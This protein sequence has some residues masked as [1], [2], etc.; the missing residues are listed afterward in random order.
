MCQTLLS[1]DDQ[2]AAIVA[3][4]QDTGRLANTLIIFTSDNG[5]NLLEHRWEGKNVPYEESIRVPLVIRY[6]PLTASLAGDH[7]AHL[8]QNLDLAPTIAAAAGV[9][10]PGATGENLLRLLSGDDAGWP[11]ERLIEHWQPPGGVASPSFCGV[12][13][14]QYTYAQYATGEEE[15][16][17]LAAD[18]PELDNRA[19]DPDLQ[20]L[21]AQLHADAMA[22]C[23][24]RPP[25]WP[26][27]IT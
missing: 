22:L 11:Q 1:V 20:D 6:D 14:A 24:P 27:T 26:R 4:L 8:V 25:H 7:D 17:D 12:R 18:P 5:I 3:A 10:A 16:Y 21:K 23:Q 13:T 19:A 2:V 15:L 9:T